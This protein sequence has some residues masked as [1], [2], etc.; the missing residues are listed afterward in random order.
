MKMIKTYS[1]YIKENQK[2]LTEPYDPEFVITI[3]LKEQIDTILQK[4]RELSNR[5]GLNIRIVGLSKVR[6]LFHIIYEGDVK[7][8]SGGI[9]EKKCIFNLRYLGFGKKIILTDSDDT[10]SFKTLEDVETHLK[11]FF[12]I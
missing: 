2:Y 4:L 12:N 6:D 7:L 3:E 8:P 10:R 1:Q 5:L 11:T 9:M